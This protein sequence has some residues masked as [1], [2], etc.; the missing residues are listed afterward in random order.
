MS[1]PFYSE[2]VRH[3]L[4]FYSRNLHIIKFR[5]FAD[6]LNWRACH[7]AISELPDKSKDI[8][9]CVYSGRDTLADEVYNASRKFNVNQNIIWDM[10][11]DFE[12]D[13]AVRRGLV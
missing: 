11:K 5:T 8:L 9:V 2:F 4:R 13:V 3:C 12:H 1:R 6:E 10:M 7:K